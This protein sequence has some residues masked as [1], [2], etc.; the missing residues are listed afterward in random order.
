MVSLQYFDQDAPR[1]VASMHASAVNEVHENQQLWPPTSIEGIHMMNQYSN[2]D[3][4]SDLESVLTDNTD[5]S[6]S[7]DSSYCSVNFDSDDISHIDYLLELQT[8]PLT[9]RQKNTRPSLDESKDCCCNNDLDV[10][11]LSFDSLED[12][13]NRG[14]VGRPKDWDPALPWRPNRRQRKNLLLIPRSEKKYDFES[15]EETI[16]NIPLK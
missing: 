12:A 9:S 16:F 13:R 1:S 15:D 5:D 10:S 8:I 2:V 7:D 3:I 6:D 11:I 14:L 4:D